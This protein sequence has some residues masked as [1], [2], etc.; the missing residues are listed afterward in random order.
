MIERAELLLKL[1][2]CELAPAQ[3]DGQGPA[4]SQLKEKWSDQLPPATLQP[5]LERWK[6]TEAAGRASGSKRWSGMIAVLRRQN[7]WELRAQD[8]EGGGAG[9]GMDGMEGEVDEAGNLVR[10]AAAREVYRYLHE[11]MVAPPSLLSQLLR[12]RNARARYRAFGLS[13]LAA[14]LNGMEL[15]SALVDATLPLRPALRPRLHESIADTQQTPWTQR[16]HYLNSLEGCA[17]AIIDEVQ[18]GFLGVYT[19][20]GSL[21]TRAAAEGDPCLG[22]VVMWTWGCELEPRDHEF[23]LRVGLAPTLAGLGSV[24]TLGAAANAVLEAANKSFEGL[25]D[26]VVSITVSE[27]PVGMLTKGLPCGTGASVSALSQPEKFSG[28]K[29]GDIVT[30]INGMDVTALESDMVRDI[31][32]GASDGVRGGHPATFKFRPL[33]AAERLWK[34]VK[35]SEVR[36][37]FARSALSKR[38]LIAHMQAC[39]PGTVKPEWWVQHRL[40][41]P[42]W[43]AAKQ[44]TVSSLL[45]AYERLGRLV[46]AASAA[47]ADADATAERLVTS[48]HSKSGAEYK[49]KD[50]CPATGA[51]PFGPSDSP[52]GTITISKPHESLVGLP[53]LRVPDADKMSRKSNVVSFVARKPLRVLVALHNRMAVPTW[54]AEWELVADKTVSVCV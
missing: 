35:V 2:P 48:I 32:K 51:K 1:S 14:L 49:Y 50:A 8:E 47:S 29:V 15:P 23:L 26:R 39:P 27:A 36:A 3:G 40:D 19:R 9:A 10:S 41:G 33:T 4:T 12:R 38:Q 30:E 13:A 44:H 53:Y 34:P 17:P 6:S 37:G 31:L 54:L 11:G 24:E 25:G 22:S 45:V 20:L 5:L 7:S 43:K 46:A 21:L 18:K 16:H 52:T 28:V 42:V